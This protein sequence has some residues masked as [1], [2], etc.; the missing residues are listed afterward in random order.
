MLTLLTDTDDTTDGPQFLFET[1][2]LDT[3]GLRTGTAALQL[4]GGTFARMAPTT[5]II[6]DTADVTIEREMPK[7]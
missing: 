2:T 5:N 1:D 7:P 3:T 6:S 4:D